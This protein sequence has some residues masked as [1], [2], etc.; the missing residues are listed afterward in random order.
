MPNEFYAMRMKTKIML[1]SLVATLSV[2]TPARTCGATPELLARQAVS[3]NALVASN[4]ILQLRNL[5]SDGLHALLTELQ[6]G[7]APLN[8]ENPQW[9]RLSAALDAVGGQRDCY[10]SR[11]FWH[12]DFEAAKSE[13]QRTG[14]PIL[15]LRLLGN[16][17]EELSCANSTLR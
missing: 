17:D 8:K 10:A 11:L 12:K 1:L 14:K 7:A 9:L 6:P 16:L 2:L 4:A 3:T 5:G 13:A 15:S